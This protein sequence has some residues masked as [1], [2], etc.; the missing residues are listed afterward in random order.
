MVIDT[1]FSF[2]QTQD[3]SRQ[4]RS[5]NPKGN[6]SQARSRRREE[7]V[8]EEI[9]NYARYSFLVQTGTA[10]MAQANQTIQDVMKLLR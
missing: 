4:D 3:D 1:A 8:V 9:T 5:G 2:G 6:F 7:D 10:M